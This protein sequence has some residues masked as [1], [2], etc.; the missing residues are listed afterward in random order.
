MGPPQGHVNARGEEY[1]KW[2]SKTAKMAKGMPVSVLYGH[3]NHK[4]AA[5]MTDLQHP[6][7]SGYSAQTTAEEV[8]ANVD[9]RDRIAIVTGGHAGLGLETTR[10]LVQAGATVIVGSRDTTRARGA[11]VGM[12]R[13]EVAHL[14]LS[15]PASIDAFAEAF[16]KGSR[17]LHALINNAGIMA[18]PLTRDARGYE[19]Q[20]ATNHLGHFQLTA[21]LWPSL[22]RAASARVITLSSA[23]HRFAPV[24]LQDPHFERRPYDKWKAYGQ[25]KTANALFSVAL[26]GRSRSHGVRALAVH[27]G[28]VGTDLVR[29]MPEAELQAAGMTRALGATEVTQGE[30]FKNLPQGA[31]TS[32]WATVSSQL[33]NIG[34][35]YCE[36]CDIAARVPNDSKASNGV[37]PWATDLQAAQALWR[38]SEA[39]TGVTWP[40]T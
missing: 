3:P 22:V 15:I 25:S 11:V 10:V 12:P 21:R 31:A 6:L 1:L 28:R 17:P 36:D 38:L 16:A 5:S 34:G 14:D 4:A 33:E 30:G 13:V 26:D 7:P 40:A 39:L 8:M 37:R 19:Q 23:G 9:W 27:P 32:V 35:V 18:L 24:D 2:G 20:F 29:H